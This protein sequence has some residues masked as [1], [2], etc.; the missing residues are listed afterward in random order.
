[1]WSLLI[2]PQFLRQ[3]FR[4]DLALADILK[5][6]PVR[7]WQLALGELLAPTAALT[8]LQWALLILVFG[9]FSQPAAASLGWPSWLGMGFGAALIIP[10][11]NLITLQIPNGAALL[12]PAWF[13]AAKGGGV[14]IEVTGQRLIFMIGQMLVFIVALT[15]AAALFAGVFFLVKML[16]SMAI[17]IPLASIAAAIVLGAEAAAGVALLGW[18]FNRF[19]VSA[20]TAA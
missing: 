11:L 19:D 12:F 14:G 10:M 7:G 6:Y 3:D 20:E 8:G 15:P 16:L 2:G 13:Q 18:L 5:T 17:A 1:L 4:Q 9:L